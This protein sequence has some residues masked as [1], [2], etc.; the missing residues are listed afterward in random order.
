[1]NRNPL[2]YELSDTAFEVLR[3]IILTSIL[4]II[5][6]PVLY[7][8]SV[9]FRSPQE[10]FSSGVYL[11]PKEP[12]FQ[13]W[14]DAIETL[15]EPLMNSAQIAT[16]TMILSLV[17]TIPGAYVFGRKEFPGK[18]IGFYGIVSALM[19][20]YIILIIPITDIWYDFN[21]HDT[22]PGMWLAYQTFVVPFAIWILRDFFE[23]LPED[24]EEAAQVYGCTRIEAFYRVILPL[25]IPAIASVGFLAFLVGWNDYLFSSL[26]TTGA[27]V[28]PAIVTLFEI[29]TG[30]ERNYWALIMASTLLVGIPP[31]VLYMFARRHI[32]NAFAVN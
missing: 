14:T 32:T 19:F 15:R 16:G 25:S 13:A 30:S 31:A 7:V 20:P 23:K 27:Q 5:V 3:L 9:S 24:L 22:I 8:I 17:I 4:A 10:F 18:R 12:T 6:L 28:Q 11:I 1:M 2:A 21:L 26:L 29:T